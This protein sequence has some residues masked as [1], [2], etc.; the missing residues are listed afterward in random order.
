MMFINIR[1]K[2]SYSNLA[3]VSFFT[4]QNYT[5]K[6]FH[7]TIFIKIII[8]PYQLQNY[9]LIAAILTIFINN[10]SIH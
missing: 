5:K 4:L 9:D 6:T 1:S 3:F 10:N 7:N 8:F 2:P